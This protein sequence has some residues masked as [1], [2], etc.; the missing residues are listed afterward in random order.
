MK[1]IKCYLKNY[2]H[3]RAPL[4]KNLEQ[5]LIYKLYCHSSPCE[6]ERDFWCSKYW[7]HTNPS[8][9]G[10]QSSYIRVVFQWPLLV[11]VSCSIAWRKCSGWNYM[12]PGPKIL[13]KMHQLSKAFLKS[14]H[15]LR[16]WQESKINFQLANADRMVFD[17]IRKIIPDYLPITLGLQDPNLSM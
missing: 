10:R 7:R 15:E 6:G 12:V 11:V 14:K 9:P 1:H 4:G 3:S 5:V 8:Q 17:R 13:Q 2:I 16:C